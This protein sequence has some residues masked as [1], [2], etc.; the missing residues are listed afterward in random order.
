MTKQ[1][2]H[3]HTHTQG[4]NMEE[5]R[6]KIVNS[7]LSLREIPKA[8]FYKR[9]LMV[10]FIKCCS[11]DVIKKGKMSQK[12]LC[13]GCDYDHPSERRKHVLGLQCN[14]RIFI[15]LHFDQLL[16]ITFKDNDYLDNFITILRGRHIPENIVTEFTDYIE[17]KNEKDAKD[18]NR[19]IKDYINLL[20]P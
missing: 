8:D 13:M 15:F 16:G 11:E 9:I 6:A 10:L 1:S 19:N 12:G 4:R 14:L 20:L 18:I 5:G 17:K 7:I 3:T 2:T